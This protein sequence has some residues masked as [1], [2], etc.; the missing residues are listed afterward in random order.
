MFALSMDMTLS[1]FLQQGFL[2]KTEI[3]LENPLSQKIT[4]LISFQ[5]LLYED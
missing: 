2:N 5:Q 3:H 4:E 1:T